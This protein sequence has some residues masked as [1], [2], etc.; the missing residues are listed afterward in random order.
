MD[1]ACSSVVLKHKCEQDFDRETSWCA[2][3]YRTEKGIGGMNIK[4]SFKESRF[5]SE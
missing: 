5:V 2:A 3:T 1:W 4:I